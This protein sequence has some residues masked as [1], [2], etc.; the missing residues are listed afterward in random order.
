MRK[1]LHYKISVFALVNKALQVLFLIVN[2]NYMKKTISTHKSTI[3][4]LI[5]RFSKNFITLFESGT[6]K[7]FQRLKDFIS[8]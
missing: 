8:S 6:K 4:L 3:T 5:S 2:P 7:D 1:I